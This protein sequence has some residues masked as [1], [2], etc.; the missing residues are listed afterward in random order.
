MKDVLQWS[1]ELKYRSEVSKKQ[2]KYSLFYFCLPVKIMNGIIT[3]HQSENKFADG[4]IQ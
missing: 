1:K 2:Q 3:D 4:F